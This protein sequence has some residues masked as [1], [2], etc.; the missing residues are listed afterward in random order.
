MVTLGADPHK[1]THTLVA[2]DDAARQLGQ[3]TFA[4]T[5]NGHLE[6][7]SW[8][9]QWS[10]R[11]WA[12]EDCRHVSRRLERDLLV[13]GE[14]VLRVPPKLMAGARS[15]ARTRGKSDPIDALAVAR[16][17]AREPGLPVA[18]LDGPSRELRLLVDHREDLVGERTRIQNRL[19]WHLHELDPGAATVGNL[20]RKKG[21]DMLDAQLACHR[22]LVAD[23]ARDQAASIR[24]LTN[25]IDALEREI[26]AR[27]IQVAPA[28]LALPGCGFLTAAKLV[29]EVGGASRFRSRAAFAMH[30]GTAPI[31][32]WS[33]RAERFRLNRG[34][35]RK[36][37]CALH[38]I[39]VTQLR[40]DG[41]GKDYIA[42]RVSLGNTK[43][44]AVRALRRRISDEVYRR[45][46][47]DEGVISEAREQAA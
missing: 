42:K 4:A 11:R 16:A 7:L 10:E 46:L 3:R 5:A 21:L 45:M 37:N 36:L 13:A 35:N 47:Q 26:I 39:A 23:L 33:G 41:P 28:L 24:S 15:S 12:M 20:S 44:E 17:A 9:S 31:P 40:L 32:V 8:A 18:T 34:G 6:A 38:L 19:R 22:G 1:A 14:T 30:N 2:I 27:T 25:R 43:R 29:G